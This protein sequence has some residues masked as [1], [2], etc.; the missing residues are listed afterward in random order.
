MAVPTD[1]DSDPT[2][3]DVASDLI[4]R[5]RVTLT[6]VRGPAYHEIQDALK[7][8]AG[9]IEGGQIGCMV[10]GQLMIGR[11]TRDTRLGRHRWSITIE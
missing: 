3:V 9:I 4:A 6:K 5:L 10:N 11:I 2:P 7:E 8:M 1:A